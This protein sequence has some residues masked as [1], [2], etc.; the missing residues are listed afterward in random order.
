MI[1]DTLLLNVWVVCFRLWNRCAPLL[2]LLSMTLC[3]VNRILADTRCDLDHPERCPQY[4]FVTLRLFTR[5]CSYNCFA[6]QD[7]LSKHSTAKRGR[8]GGG[9]R[10]GR[11]PSSAVNTDETCI[12]DEPQSL[13]SAHSTKGRPVAQVAR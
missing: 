13:F 1:Q 8:G 6:L 11:L 2:V 5:N 4:T 7:S 12:H 10:G 9:V 3:T